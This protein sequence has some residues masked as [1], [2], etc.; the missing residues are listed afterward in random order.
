MPTVN[1]ISLSN[2]EVNELRALVKE[3]RE[4][5]TLSMFVTNRLDPQGTGEFPNRELVQTYK[6]LEGK[7]LISGRPRDGAFT[8][9]GLDQSGIDWIDDYDRQSKIDAANEKSGH[10]HDYRVAIVSVIASIAIT[11]FIEHFTEIVNSLL[12]L[13]LP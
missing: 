13:I 8:F 5:T 11:L 3:K 10:M 4:G 12:N 9:I 6:S 1:D 2:N 7:K